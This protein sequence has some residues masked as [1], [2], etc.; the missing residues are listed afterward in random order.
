MKHKPRLTYSVEETAYLLGVHELTL[1]AAIDRGEIKTVR[2]GRRVLIP[3][4]VLE[5]L[6]SPSRE[7][8]Q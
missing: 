3:R 8:A 7:E 2:V 6:L 4:Q 1:R 5:Q